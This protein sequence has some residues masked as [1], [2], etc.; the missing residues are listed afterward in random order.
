MM[1]TEFWSRLRSVVSVTLLLFAMGC[2]SR[3]ETAEQRVSIQFAD[4][5]VFC[6]GQL[7]VT[8]RRGKVRERAR[9]GI[10]TYRYPDGKIEQE[11]EYDSDGDVSKCRQ[12]APD[13]KLESEETHTD[14]SS[15]YRDYYEN[16]TLKREEVVE[17]EEKEIDTDGGTKTRR[18]EKVC[19]RTYTADGSVFDVERREYVD[20]QL[21]GVLTKHDPAGKEV[22]RAYYIDE[23]MYADRRGTSTVTRIPIPSSGE[24]PI[25]QSAEQSSPYR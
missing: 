18:I 23:Q 20:G 1:K 24:T 19:V 7:R 13:G 5:T 11:I 16:G 21:K 25:T 14:D 15:T 9:T 12:F 10:W 2:R 8:K 17:K 3:E 22:L 4:G 6:A